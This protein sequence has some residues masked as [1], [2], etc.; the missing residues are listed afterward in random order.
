MSYEIITEILFAKNSRLAINS[1]AKL[2]RSFTL[3]FQYLV[4]V[5]FFTVNVAFLGH[6]EGWSAYI[7][8]QLLNVVVE[9][10]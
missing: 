9:N 4:N 3:Y 5:G 8:R 2:E 10:R 1:T 7:D 6:R